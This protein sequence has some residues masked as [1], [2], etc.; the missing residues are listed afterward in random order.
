MDPLTVQTHLLPWASSLKHS[1]QKLD[2][3]LRAAEAMMAARVPDHGD[4]C[5]RIY[6]RYA[7]TTS[8][9]RAQAERIELLAM[10]CLMIATLT[11]QP[12]PH[13]T[14]TLMM[15]FHT[16]NRT[17]GARVRPI[18][19]DEWNAACTAIAL[20]GTGGPAHG[21]LTH[22]LPE[23]TWRQDPARCEVLLAAM[24]TSASCDVDPFLRRLEQ[25]TPVDAADV[26]RADMAL[27]VR[28][29]RQENPPQEVPTGPAALTL[30]RELSDRL[31]RAGVGDAQRWQA[32]E[33][34][35][36]E[37]MGWMGA[38]NRTQLLE[39]MLR[40]GGC[41]AAVEHEESGGSDSAAR[42]I[43]GDQ[44][45][46]MEVTSRRG[47]HMVRVP[48]WAVDTT[49][50]QVFIAIY[51]EAWADLLT[52]VRADDTP[53]TGFP[54]PGTAGPQPWDPALLARLRQQGWATAGAGVGAGATV[55]QRIGANPVLVKVSVASVVIVMAAVAGHL[56][57]GEHTTLRSLLAPLIAGLGSLI[58]VSMRKPFPV[59][60]P[61]IPLAVLAVYVWMTL[62]GSDVGRVLVFAAFIPADYGSLWMDRRRR[63]HPR[64]R[65]S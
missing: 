25:E 10:T 9:N 47:Q 38:A 5:A 16:V 52:W 46:S 49:E 62:A 13:A 28:R 7:Q 37:L 64:R 58:T 48:G 55:R 45:R 29:N 33:Q 24:E 63:N 19:D 32:A 57:V 44:L 51:P 59:V 42:E 40:E 11:P 56:L 36:L 65:R 31:V 50:D 3:A 35:V 26:A 6:Q 15:R 12:P 20:S 53:I 21:L 60:T 30:Y 22:M 8:V 43:A 41:A 2:A 4:V 14:Q 61:W 17:Q 54:Q 27:Q 23:A 39:V 18:H 1:G 34:R